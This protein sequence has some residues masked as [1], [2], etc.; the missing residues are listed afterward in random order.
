MV[1]GNCRM[2]NIN[3]DLHRVK[4]YAEGLGIKVY[5]KDYYRGAGG[6]DWDMENQNI[7]IYVH[8]GQSKTQI[9]LTLLH[10]LGHH[11]DWIYNDKKIKKQER[12]A[13]QILCS[14]HMFGKRN[15][16]TKRQRKL[17]LDSE[18]GG[19]NYMSL[20]HKELNL[21]VPLWKVKM[22]QDLDIYDYQ[23]L[24]DYGRFATT[25]E[26][27]EYKNKIKSYYMEKYK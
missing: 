23:M 7:T 13:Q 22:Q 26:F 24:Y 12:K 4:K 10:E 27:T 6:A 8:K 19:V 3:N 14:G 18:I 20:I 25:E 2:A 17:I 11:L 1:N 16:L 15:D 5:F 9:L 21:S